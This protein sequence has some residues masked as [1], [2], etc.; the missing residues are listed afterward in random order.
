MEE[1]IKDTLI[2]CEKEK[3]I[4]FNVSFKLIL[5]FSIFLTG[6]STLAGLYFTFY[7][8]TGRI[9]DTF[10]M[11]DFL[12][13]SLLYINILICLISLISIA[14]IKKP[15]SKIL[16]RCF[17]AI[18]I[19]FLA[20]SFVFPRISGYH[21]SGFQIFSTGEFTLIDGYLLMIGLL[22]TLFSRLIHYGFIYQKDSDMTV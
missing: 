11:H 1:E 18:G 21:V 19:V 13:N 10:S 8:I 15:F 7:F 6:I 4:K 14:V 3:E 20:A 2:Q 22:G 16:V 5:G 12:V 9:W 17:Q